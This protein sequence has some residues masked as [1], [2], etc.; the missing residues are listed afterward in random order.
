MIHSSIHQKRNQYFGTNIRNGVC[1]VWWP[2]RPQLIHTIGQVYTYEIPMGNRVRIVAS[3][4]HTRL[5]NRWRF[6]PISIPMGTIFVPYP[7]PNRGIPHGLAGIGSP[8][9]SLLSV[10]RWSFQQQ[11]RLDARAPVRW[12][13]SG[14]SVSDRAR[15]IHR[16]QHRIRTTDL[17]MCG[18]HGILVYLHLRS[19]MDRTLMIR[20]L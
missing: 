6:C 19:N 14:P 20:R 17:K 8:L 12:A 1:R 10:G 16:W 5:P 18:R 9:T 3:Q 15:G 4:T 11:S 2:T 7:Y 13:Q